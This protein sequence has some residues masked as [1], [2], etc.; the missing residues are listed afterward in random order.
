MSR[1]RPQCAPAL[2]LLLKICHPPCS[3][4]NGANEGW[5]STNLYDKKPGLMSHFLSSDHE[6]E[7][8]HETVSC[9]M[10]LS[11]ETFH[12]QGIADTEH[13]DGKIER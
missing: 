7:T 6:H 3:G 2:H 10:K 13:F 4:Q 5:N 12:I 1:G 8:S 9:F 11:H